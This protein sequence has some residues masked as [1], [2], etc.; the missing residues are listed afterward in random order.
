MVSPWVPVTV[1]RKAPLTVAT[2]L[3]M[4]IRPETVPRRSSGTRSGRTAM[5]AAMAAFSATW[6]RH[7]PTRTTGRLGAMPMT[8]RDAL[9]TTAPVMMNG[10]R[11]PQREVQR[12]LKCPKTGLAIM[13]NIAPTPATRAKEEALLSGSR[14]AMRRDSVTDAGVS[15]A[16]QTPMMARMYRAVKPPPTRWPVQPGRAFGC[17]FSAVGRGGRGM[18]CGCGHGDSFVERAGTGLGGA[19]GEAEGLTGAERL[20]GPRCATGLTCAPSAE[21]AELKVLMAGR[22]PWQWIGERADRGREF[23]RGRGGR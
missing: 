9:P 4:P 11:R 7:Q 15:R 14:S 18:G 16:I 10:R 6:V 23:R 12:S 20:T 1:T 21:R 22:V 19:R 5:R 8:T 13:A 3:V 17:G 2:W